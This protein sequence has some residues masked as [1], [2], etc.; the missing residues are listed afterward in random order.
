MARVFIS[1]SKKHRARTERIAALLERQEIVVPD[2]KRERMTVWWD[3]RLLSGDY[4][5][6]FG[7]SKTRS[8]VCA[9]PRARYPH[10]G[11]HQIPA[12]PKCA[13]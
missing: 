7:V 4:A 1:Y 3:T 8:K 2:G 11:R 12:R 9:S 10:E 5:D 13:A 6:A